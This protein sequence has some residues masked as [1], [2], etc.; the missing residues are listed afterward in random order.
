MIIPMKESTEEVLE[1][2]KRRRYM[3]LTSRVLFK[4]IIGK[5]EPSYK[6]PRGPLYVPLAKISAHV[7]PPDYDDLLRLEDEMVL[8]LL[9]HSMIK[10]HI[11]ETRTIDYEVIDEALIKIFED[12]YDVN[13]FISHP[14]NA[15]ISSM[16]HPWD[17][18]MSDIVPR[19]VIYV[20]SGGFYTGPCPVRGKVT[21][22]FE[23]GEM[24][25][26]EEIGMAIINDDSI[27]CIRLI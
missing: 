26:E 14:D 24:I 4:D 3:G 18:Y 8:C 1:I 22:R 7:Y 5:K 12:G 6:T 19:D 9:K 13:Y 11:V 21:V 23:R 27:S 2:V 15:H 25:A 17:L 16:I 10:D 20:A